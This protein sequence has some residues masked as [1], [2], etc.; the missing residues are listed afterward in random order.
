[1]ESHGASAGMQR[2]HEITS[3]RVFFA[4][5]GLA[6]SPLRGLITIFIYAYVT[7]VMSSLA[8]PGICNC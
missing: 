6:S 1:M 7:P 4:V 3:G 2:A 5:T 8:R